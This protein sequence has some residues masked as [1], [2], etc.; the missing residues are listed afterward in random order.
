M[1]KEGVV[2]YFCGPICQ[3]LVEGLG[4]VLRCKMAS[5]KLAASI[6][7]KVFSVLVEQVQNIVNY[8]S[9][10]GVQASGEMYEMLLDE[11]RLGVGQILVSHDKDGFI[12]SC[13]NSVTKDAEPKIREKIET[14]NNL[15]RD[16]LK[17][18]YKEQRRRPSRPD[19]LGAGLG[20]IEMARKSSCPLTYSFDPLDNGMLFFV[21][22]A[23]LGKDGGKNVAK[24]PGK[25][26][27]R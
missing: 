25:G 18:Y 24:D 21:V 3:G 8:S 4:E 15:N 2:L 7:H 16:Q 10:K 19:S 5:D 20:F 1:E 6:A 13:G 22:N 26:G 23:R 14:V 9:Q 11:P 27:T 17:A 12:V